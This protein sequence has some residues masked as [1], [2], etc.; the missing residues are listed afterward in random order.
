M[1]RL[2]VARQGALLPVA[3]A[4]EGVDFMKKRKEQEWKAKLDSTRGMAQWIAIYQAYNATFKLAE[5]AL[6]AQRL[7]LPQ[8]Y[9]LGVLKAGGGM[10]TTGEI[11]RA[12]VRQ[13]QT[14]TGLVDRLE[15]PGLVERVFDTRDRRK[16]WVRLT[17]KGDRK[18][19]EALPVATRLAEELFS[20]LSDQEL[21]E[22]QASVEKLVRAATDRLA[23]TLLPDGSMVRRP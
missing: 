1:R 7:S 15:E 23:A 16:T 12:M 11:G 6:L 9:L 5:L 3:N 8:I 22:L 21:G 2:L 18:L 4:Q 13:S 20:S 14:M 10:L 17:E 19:E